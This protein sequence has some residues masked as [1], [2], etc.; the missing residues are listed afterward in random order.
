ML[1]GWEFLQT[2][3]LYGSEIYKYWKI[4]LNLYTTPSITIHPEL[5]IEEK[6]YGE[7]T[8]DLTQ[9]QAN[10]YA[11]VL[12]FFNNYNLCTNVGYNVDNE[13]LFTVETS[14]NFQDC[15]KILIETL[16]TVPS[17]DFSPLWDVC[18]ASNDEAVQLY[19]YNPITS[20]VD[21]ILAGSGA[22]GGDLCV[23]LPI[24]HSRAGR[25]FMKI[26]ESYMDTLESQGAFDKTN[27]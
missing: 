21:T 13:V 18:T 19:K 27:K 22:N 4:R 14:M 16:L 26:F 24:S 15:Y 2:Y 6:Y 23:T 12:L 8:A 10:L 17:F 25:F 9:F 20:Q 7:V 1:L 11:E 3:S 5:Q